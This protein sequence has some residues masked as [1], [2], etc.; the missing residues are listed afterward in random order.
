MYS[1]FEPM[2]FK[3]YIPFLIVSALA[4][5]VII[6]SCANQGMPTGGPRDSIPPVLTGT[7]PDYKSL[8]FDGDEIRLTF[9]EYIDPSDISEE[10]VVSPPLTKRP[11]IRTKSKT[12]IVQF[13]EELRDSVTYSL[14]FKNSIVDNNEQNPYEGMRFS[15]STGDVFDTLRVAGKVINGF[16]LEAVENTLVALH[17]NL[18]DS[19]VFRAI[20]DYIAKT[21]KNG[22]FMI[23]NIAPGSYHIFSI[24]DANN[25]MLYNE[26]AEE[27]AFLDTLVVPSAEFHEEMDTLVKG[28]D[29][30]L[31]TGHIHFHPDP[32]YLRQFMEDIFEQYLDSYERE[33]RYKCSFVFNE[34]VEDSFAVHLI[35]KTA[36]DW[37][38]LEPNV[39][40]DSLTLWIADT[41]VANTDSLFMEVLYYQLDSMNQLYIQKDTL[42]MNF[43]EKEEPERKRRKEKNE[44]SEESEEPEPIPQF[45]WSTNISST[46]DLNK[47]I[48]VTAPEPVKTFNSDN[49]FL[50]LSDDTLK[51]PLPF[52]FEKDSLKWRTYKINYAWEPETSYTLK[53]D[54]AACE[55]IYGI[56]SK[57]LEKSFN[58]REEDYYGSIILE[59]T[60]IEC[61]MLVQLIT[62]NDDE[63]V[64]LEQT[65]RENKSITFNYLG[66]EKYKLKVIYDKNDNGKWDSGSFQD[67]YQ[68]EAVAYASEVI[69]VRSNWENKISWDLTPDPTFTKN[70]RDKELEEQR[71]KEA[72]EK[73]RMERE[74]QNQQRQGQ[75]NLL[76]QGSGSRNRNSQIRRQ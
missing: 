31:V 53:I 14:D 71:R 44:E 67:N 70:I 1:I 21:D 57:K 9:N 33:T 76:Q 12:L 42:E 8:N 2:K 7:Q 28:V 39:K 65:V 51:T 25:D 20:P 5:I 73:A 75:N 16:N 18:H 11:I 63:N 41:V 69:K 27:I 38:I 35:D 34:S 40:M 22:L 43:V 46:F 58:T 24:N 62:N 68:P 23:D 32:F 74:Q 60:G 47:K 55:N 36:D 17:K 61:P 4:W 19:A 26:G 64:L 59:L 49:V 29:S 6:S 13:N 72:E 48:S 45:N 52:E 56:T 15:F 54:S 66:P 3:G 37:Y 50:Y 30:L 10:L